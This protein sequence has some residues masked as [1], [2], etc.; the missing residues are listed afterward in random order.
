M[1]PGVSRFPFRIFSRV[2]RGRRAKQLGAL[3]ESLQGAGC[4]RKEWEGFYYRRRAQLASLGGQQ[5]RAWLHAAGT[6]RP[7]GD[8][9]R[10]GSRLRALRPGREP[11]QSEPPA[12]RGPPPSRRPPVRGAASGHDR[13]TRGAAAGARRPR[14]KKTRRRSTR[15]EELT[16]SEELT[17]SEEATWERRGGPE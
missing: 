1:P 14:M 11:R 13:P 16:R 5:A 9:E 17:M 15:G 6:R 12:Q 4:W 10:L 2:F 8:R 7:R 3:G